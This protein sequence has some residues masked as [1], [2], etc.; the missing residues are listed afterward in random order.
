MESRPHHPRPH[1]P[2][3]DHS[4]PR[5]PLPRPKPFKSETKTETET[6]YF[7]CQIVFYSKNIIFSLGIIFFYTKNIIFS[8]GILESTADWVLFSCLYFIFFFFRSCGLD[9]VVSS[10]TRQRPWRDETETRPRPIKSGLKTSITDQWQ[11]FSSIFDTTRIPFIIFLWNYDH[12]T[13]L[14]DN[15]PFDDTP[16][17]DTPSNN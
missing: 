4:R 9:R 17:C 3:P 14:C 8:L 11:G 2:R 13:S 5:P 10:D 1:H 15:S 12:V 7:S 6:Q 16:Q